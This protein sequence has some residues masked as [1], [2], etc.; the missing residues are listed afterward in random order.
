MIKL[1]EIPLS[2]NTTAAFYLI[3]QKLMKKRVNLIL[4]RLE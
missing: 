1:K 4:A 3:T 2:S